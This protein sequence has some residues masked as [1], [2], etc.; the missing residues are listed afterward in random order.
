MNICDNKI[1]TICDN[2]INNEYFRECARLFGVEM[3]VPAFLLRIQHWKA[4]GVV[5]AR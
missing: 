3:V 4:L 2:I 1:I 5:G